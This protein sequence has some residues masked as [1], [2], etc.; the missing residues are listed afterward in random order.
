MNVEIDQATLEELESAF[1]FNDAVIRNLVI[2]R[3]QAATGHSKI[4]EEELKDQERD[5]E[6]D[7]RRR[8]DEARK[9]AAEATTESADAPEAP[10][11]PEAAT[12]ETES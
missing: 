9:P 7:S 10:E 3:K 6:R 4:Y 2:R 11:A 12:E 8:E 1:R 5:R